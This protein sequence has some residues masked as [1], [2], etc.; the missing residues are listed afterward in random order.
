MPLPPPPPVAQ[1]LTFPAPLAASTPAAADGSSPTSLAPPS[2]TDGSLAEAEEAEAEAAAEREF[3][4]ELAAAEALL[5]PPQPAQPAATVAPLAGANAP[6]L[7][8][9]PP[10]SELRYVALVLGAGVSVFAFIMLAGWL[11]FLLSLVYAYW[12]PQIILNVRRGSA[13]S[14]FRA[15]YVLGTTAARLVL[16][17]YFWAFPDNILSVEPSRWVLLLVAYSAA[18]AGVLLLQGSGAG[19]RWFLPL[20]ARAWLEFEEEQKWDYHPA[21][22]SGQAEENAREEACAICLEKVE[23]PGKEER[24]GKRGRQGYM[25]PPCK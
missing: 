24:E 1:P 3:E 19:A 18:Q 16:P 12:L 2:H 22:L 14:S 10:A 7:L 17:L 6:Q 25:V 21:E 4:A 20:R 23:V 9:V 13:R 15:E 5:S 11:P 8:Q